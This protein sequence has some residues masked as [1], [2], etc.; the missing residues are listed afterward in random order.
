MHSFI[1][2]H[3]CWLGWLCG[4]AF[5]QVIS[6]ALTSSAN[7]SDIQLTCVANLV[8]FITFILRGKY[9]VYKRLKT[10]FH[11]NK[12]LKN[13]NG[14]N[15]LTTNRGELQECSV[16]MLVRRMP[17]TLKKLSASLSLLPSLSCL[18][19][20]CHGC[21]R[22]LLHVENDGLREGDFHL[23]SPAAVCEI[24]DL[25]SIHKVSLIIV[26]SPAAVCEII[27]SF[28][29]RISLHI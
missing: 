2:I 24:L 4:L 23:E 8:A 15:V 7:F 21:N 5:G 17:G 20:G 25:K 9:H 26:K 10:I 27:V 14:L 3:L 28:S 18:R 29:Q 22:R 16:V 19:N 11:I 13:I 6:E 12:K 1:I